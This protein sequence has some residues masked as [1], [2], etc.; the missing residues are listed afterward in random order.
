MRALTLEAGQGCSPASKD[1]DP[2]RTV[3][4]TVDG[5]LKQV[6]FSFRAETASRRDVIEY[7]ANKAGGAH[8]DPRRRGAENLLGRIRG[9]LTASV[10]GD[11]CQISTNIDR[12]VMPSDDFVFSPGALDCVLLELKAACRFLTQSDSIRLLK[13]SVRTDLDAIRRTSP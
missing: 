13:E 12:V 3:P 8:F 7:V 1:F 10:E 6:V 11:V 5:F 2:G 4:L 9:A